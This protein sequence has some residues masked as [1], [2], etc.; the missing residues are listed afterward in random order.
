MYLDGI[1]IIKSWETTYGSACKFL[2]LDKGMCPDLRNQ[3]YIGLHT[4]KHVFAICLDIDIKNWAAPANIPEP[5]W[6]T[7]NPVSRH[8]HAVW[9]IQGA[10]EKRNTKT[11]TLLN[12]IA[13]R[14]AFACGGATVRNINATQN[15]YYKLPDGSNGWIVQFGYEERYSL[16][17][18]LESTEKLN[19]PMSFRNDSVFAMLGRNCF[20]F[21]H[22]ISYCQR[23][24][25]VDEEGISLAVQAAASKAAEVWKERGMLDEGELSDIAESI[26]GYAGRGYP[27]MRRSRAGRYRLDALARSRTTSASRAKAL[28]VSRS[29]YYSVFAK[30][31]AKLAVR[32]MDICKRKNSL[33][34]GAL[35]SVKVAQELSLDTPTGMNSITE[36]PRD[37]N[38][39]I[40][41]A[42]PPP[43]PIN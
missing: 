31:P 11:I 32:V 5:T 39:A 37:R 13:M 2:K 3:K 41:P 34:Q 15:P 7:W 36:E 23:K 40:P 27:Y 18:L 19:I 9:L 4:E 26:A 6:T 1:S 21:K 42:E 33:L 12:D 29:H 17:F 24:D 43:I 10:V 16:N 28:G 35:A 38:T 22:A 30:D 8:A 14:L 25:I 20:T